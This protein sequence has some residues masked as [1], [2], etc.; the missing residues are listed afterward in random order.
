M[1]TISV[2]NGY[3]T[4]LGLNVFEWREEPLQ[5]SEVPGAIWRDTDSAAILTIGS[6]NHGMT[7]EVEIF[8]LG[9]TAPTIMRKAM[10]DVIK[11]VGLNRTWTG[12]AEDT[13]PGD[14][15]INTEKESRRIAS[16]TVS[17]GVIY[18]TEQ[19]DPYN[20]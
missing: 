8:A 17:F 7:V 2:A 11:L 15:D 19:F 13:E 4:A 14:E 20:Q 18:T 5:E 6:H 12:L 3:E 1:K 16:A 9:T 10:S